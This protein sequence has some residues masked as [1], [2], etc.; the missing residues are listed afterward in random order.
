[1]RVYLEFAKK[2]FLNKM[3]YKFDYIVGIIST[4]L[5]Y[6]IFVCIYKALYGGAEEVNGITFSMVTTSF[7]LSLC[8]SNV[9]RFNDEFIEKKLKD[10]T[11]ANEFLKPVS[12]RGR[13]LSENL[14]ENFFN[15]CFNF[16]PVF[17]IAS[18][19]S[20]VQKPSSI[21]GFILFIISA[22]LGY[23]ILWQMSFIVQAL[24]FWMYRVWGI[25]T[26]K[27]VVIY[28]FSGAAIPLW[29]MP[30][31]VLNFIKLTPFDSIYFTPVKLY[32][33]QIT[34]HDF[35]WNI[36]RQALWILILYVIGDILWKCGE[37]KVVVQGG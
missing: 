25:A 1:M 24:A 18:L 11:I 9:Y 2:S 6:V 33:G 27:D 23:L 5:T 26:I 29:F 8:L 32:L 22:I 35:A 34:S 15:I 10:G 3:V 37:K 17:L 21:E 36:G 20:N 31:W 13:I 12:F 14:G 28:I 19:F 16:L 7:V 30:N 4:I